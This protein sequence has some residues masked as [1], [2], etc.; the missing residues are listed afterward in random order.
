MRLEALDQLVDPPPGT[1]HQHE[2]DVG[3]APG[4]PVEH[5]EHQRLVLAGF[6]RSGGEHEPNAVEL[7]G[8]RTRWRREVGTGHDH[9]EVDAAGPRCP[10]G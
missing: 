6:D 7:F 8:Q 1:S 4:Q 9:R 5:V 2:V 10:L 3:E